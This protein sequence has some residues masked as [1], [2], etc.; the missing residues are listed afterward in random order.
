MTR[1]NRRDESKEGSRIPGVRSGCLALLVVLAFGFFSCQLDKIPVSAGAQDSEYRVAYWSGVWL[2]A[3]VRS[4]SLS[5]S[6]HSLIADSLIVC[7]STLSWSRDGTRILFT[8]DWKICAINSDGTQLKTLSSDSSKDAFAVWSPEGLRVA[9]QSEQG[10]KPDIYVMFRDGTGKKRL[11]NSVGGARMPSWSPDGWR[12][13]YMGDGGIHVINVDGTS[14][15]QLTNY[16]DD[17]RPLWSPNGTKILF[18]SRRDG[19]YE[20]YVM[21]PDGSD[22]RNISTNAATDDDQAWSPDGEEIVFV[23]DRDAGP[24]EQEHVYRRR[25]LYT[26]NV[27]GS[28]LIRI[29]YDSYASSPAWSPD[30]LWIVYI[31]Y[32]LTTS[33]T[34]YVTVIPSIG[35]TRTTRAPGFSPVWS[36]VKVE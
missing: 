26:V 16:S 8:S 1:F 33:G 20:V 7:D 25:E 5:G 10:G 36:P 11:T 35:G 30:G 13:A 31:N 21:N 6:E 3:S 4:V 9:Y 24:D 19:N 17:F 28:R 12:I 32:A 18:R 14:D 2:L 22:Q 34:P 23:S 15:H 27:D 29:T